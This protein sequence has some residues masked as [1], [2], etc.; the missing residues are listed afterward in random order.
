MQ[1]TQSTVWFIRVQGRVRGPFPLAKL[2]QL[3]DQG[4]LDHRTEISENRA[5]WMAAGSL[6]E[7]YPP[8]SIPV[9]VVK[10]PHDKA[11]FYQ[12][13]GQRVGPVPLT[14]LQLMASSGQLEP[15]ELVWAEGMATWGPASHVSELGY[16]Q[17]GPRVFSSFSTGKKILVLVPVL[18]LFIVP[19]WFVLKINYERVEEQK[20]VAE[21]ARQDKIHQEKMDQQDRI[22]RDDV[23]R[24]ERQRAEDLDIEERKIAAARSHTAAVQE[25][26]NQANMHAERQERQLRDIDMGTVKRGFLVA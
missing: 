2:Q 3:R 5:S 12:Q 4:R 25:N 16:L 22:H 17:L 24:Q 11:W 19:A 13:D 10:G 21:V 15:H 26:A 9:E 7:L 20:R 14:T 23:A 6:L 18:A 1:T 8:G